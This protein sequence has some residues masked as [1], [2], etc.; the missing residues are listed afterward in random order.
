VRSDDRDGGH[1]VVGTRLV[2]AAF[3][4]PPCFDFFLMAAAE[5]D[6][7][8]ACLNLT[9]DSGVRGGHGLLYNSSRKAFAREC[10]INLQRASLLRSMC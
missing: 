3:F 4:G 6:E 10:L 2:R 7:F 8:W 5:L 1:R 9:R